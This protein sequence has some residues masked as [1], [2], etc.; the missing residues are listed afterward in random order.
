MVGF[1]METENLLENA[2][3]K[4]EKKH[5]DL[6]AANSLTEAGAGFGTDTNAVTLIGKD[7]TQLRLD[8]ADKFDI[9]MQILDETVK[10]AK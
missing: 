7:G 9:A 5:L 3:K 8:T 10:I 4:L 1:C 2:R 6:I